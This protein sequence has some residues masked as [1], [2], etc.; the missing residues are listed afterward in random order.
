MK[1]ATVSYGGRRVGSVNRFKLYAIWQNIR[2]RTCANGE[3]GKLG[4]RMYHAWQEDFQ[5]FIS[6]VGLPPAHQYGLFRLDTRRDW[7]PGNVTWA[8]RVP[9]PATGRLELIQHGDQTKTAGEWA[10]IGHMSF[11]VFKYRRTAGW[12]MD[13][14]MSTPVRKV[15]KKVKRY[16]PHY[17][18]V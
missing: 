12:T 16:L 3:D 1:I 15:S 11:D 7:A 10:R 4:I 8:H 9:V 18:F 5:Q 17:D 14:I 2:A 13:Q 6:D